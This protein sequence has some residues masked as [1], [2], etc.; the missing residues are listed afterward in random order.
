MVDEVVCGILRPNE[1]RNEEIRASRQ[2]I[3]IIKS[4]D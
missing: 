1:V 4:K 3:F 2:K